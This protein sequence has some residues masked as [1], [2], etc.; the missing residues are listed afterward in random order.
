[1]LWKMPESR[2]GNALMGSEQ[3]TSSIGP[4]S[5]ASRAQQ[6]RRIRLLEEVTALTEVLF[7]LS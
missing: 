7:F 5:A 4:V 2:C 3:L 1:L 6:E